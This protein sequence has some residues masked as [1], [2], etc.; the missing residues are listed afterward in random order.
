MARPVLERGW[1]ESTTGLMWSFPTRSHAKALAN[2][3]T[4]VARGASAQRS[5]S[6]LGCT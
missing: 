2:F 5:T 4:A 1:H 3:G 6:A